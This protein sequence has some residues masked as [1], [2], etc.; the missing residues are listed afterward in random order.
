M[1]QK[2]LNHLK[3]SRRLD[4]YISQ[5]SHCQSKMSN[6]EKK[7][8]FSERHNTVNMINSGVVRVCCLEFDTRKKLELFAA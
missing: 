6:S 5:L 2:Y 3:F 1:S 4:L 7:K 8:L